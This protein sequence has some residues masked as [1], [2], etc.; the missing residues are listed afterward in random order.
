[1]QEKFFS[2][3]VV[4]LNPGEKLKKTLDSIVCQTFDDYEVILKDGGSQDKSLQEL[5]ENGFLPEHPQI[6]VVREPDKGIYDAMNQA[7]KLAAGRYIQFL[8]CGDYLHN[9]N[10]LKQVAGL[11]GDP[12]SGKEEAGIYYGNQY[13][14][15]Q[16]SVVYSAP[17]INDFTCYRN[18]PCHQV[19]FYAKELFQERGYKTKYRVRADYEHFLYCIYEKKRRAVYLPLLVASYEGGGFSETA[20]NRKCSAKEHREITFHYLGAK[21]V[22][23]YRLVMWLTLMPLRRKLAE[24]P[25]FSGWYNGIKKGIYRLFLKG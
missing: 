25:A 11:I 17:R 6:R 18:V 7:V 19:C 23:Q 16:K 5:E 24:S 14:R 12:E 1:M 21:K 15:L 13:N 2:I 8:N 3:I 22:Y 4:A 20:K 9:E 10:V